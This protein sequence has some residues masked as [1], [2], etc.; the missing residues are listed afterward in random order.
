MRHPQRAPLREPKARIAAPEHGRQRLAV[1]GDRGQVVPRARHRI[2]RRQRAR[3]DVGK[4]LFVLKL[5]RRVFEPAPH[6]REEIL[7]RR[8]ERD[9]PL[10]DARHD[11]DLHAQHRSEWRH[12]AHRPHIRARID[13]IDA[14]LLERRGQRERGLLARRRQPRRWGRA[15]RLGVTD[16]EK[17]HCGAL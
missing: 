12:R 7:L 1:R 3:R 11:P 5:E 6:M 10:T 14:E 2:D 15:L 4:T 8:K 17:R 13:G 16:Q 9:V